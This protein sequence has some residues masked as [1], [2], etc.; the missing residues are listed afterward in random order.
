MEAQD[1]ST[2]GYRP[3]IIAGCCL[4]LVAASSPPQSQAISSLPEDL[5]GQ[6]SISETT[7]ATPD[8]AASTTNEAPSPQDGSIDVTSVRVLDEC[9]VAE[10]CINRF[11]WKLYERTPKVDDGEVY[12]RK[13]VTVHKR[14]KTITVTRTVGR[15]VDS[16]FAWKDVKAATKA[17][18]ALMDYV[19]GGMDQGFKSKLFR[20]LYAAE[21]A[22]LSPGITS[23][24]RD[25]YRQSI[26]SGLK[27]AS[28]K[29]Y[30]GG[31]SHGGYGHGLAADVIC[32][33]GND[34]AER[35]AESDV[36]W[37]W[38]DQH[39]REFGIGRPYLNWDRPHVAP[40]DGVE[41]AHHRGGA[42]HLASSRIRGR[43]HLA[44]AHEHRLTRRV[45][46]ARFSKA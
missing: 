24:F 29:S 39:G 26:A 8:R 2:S 45:R 35:L 40:I 20:M 42:K 9:L 27:A 21:K 5:S 13:E 6:K 7:A 43:R 11:L 16:D 32:T 38:I 17:K 41:Y 3:A 33:K 31:S 23:G 19:I 14:G 4:V 36:L 44:A 18:I 22:G 46:V 37:K 15:S 30:H 25:D 10:T 12:E 34:R 28:S 1:Q